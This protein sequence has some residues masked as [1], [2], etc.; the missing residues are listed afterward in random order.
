MSILELQKRKNTSKGILK[1][2]IKN[3]LLQY[4]LQYKCSFAVSVE[5]INDMHVK[6]MKMV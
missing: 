2:S 1:L 4:I 3:L 6:Y 5:F